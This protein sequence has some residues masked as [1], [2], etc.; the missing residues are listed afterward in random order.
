M[1]AHPLKLGFIGLGIMGAPMA[2]HLIE[3]GHRLFVHTRGKVPPGIARSGATHVHRRATA[4]PSAPTS[5]SSWC[6][7]RRDVE[8]VLFGEDGVAA[9]CRKGKIG[10]RHEL[11]LADRDQG[12]SPEA[13][14]RSAATISM[15]R[16]RAARSAPRRHR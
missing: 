3:A 14:T 4:W 9:A 10:R 1:T 16:C 2:G 8:E 15:R 11:D 13:S 7:T 5:S 12:S 6:P